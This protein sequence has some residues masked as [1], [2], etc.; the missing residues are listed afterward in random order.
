MST[1]GTSKKKEL[2]IVGNFS[3]QNPP[4][5]G[6]LPYAKFQHGLSGVQDF[7]K[8]RNSLCS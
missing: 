6:I 3:W 5:T 2:K 8:L 7:Q 4:N 1:Q